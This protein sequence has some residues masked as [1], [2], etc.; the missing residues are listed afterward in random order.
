MRV[1]SYNLD[2]CAA[3][4]ELPGLV[5]RYRPDV[6][7]VQECQSNGMPEL[8]GGLVLVDN[9]ESNRLGLAAYVRTERVSVLRSRRYPV[10]KSLH[11]QV[12]APADERL[13]A[14]HV[15]DDS[16]GREA[17]IGSFHGAP[18]TARNAL[19]RQQID[20]AHA[21]LHDLGGDVP[22][23]MV[24]DFNYPWFIRRLAMHLQA[25]GYSVARSAARTYQRRGV[26]SGRFD[27]VTFAG[28]HVGPIEVL[29]K[30]ASDH[31]PLLFE[32]EPAGEAPDPRRLARAEPCRGEA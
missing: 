5:D 10:R 27:L 28:F 6:V 19:R 31:R 7:C 32:A 18:L 15:R 13:L 16:T 30:G 25:S 12:L 11:D 29:A 17:V 3:L 1:L 26:F 14:V 22:T 8:P 4:G 24:G 2:K 21:D 23:L 9:T 20:E